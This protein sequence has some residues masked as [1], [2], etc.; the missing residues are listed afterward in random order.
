[1]EKFAKGVVKHRKII[2]IVYL[3]LM[4]PAVIGMVN[5][6]INYDMLSYLPKNLDSVKGQQIMLDNFGKG[7]FSYMLVEDKTPA[8]CA[9]LQTKIEALDH[10]D[11]VL[12]Y[13]TL[14][15]T[16]VPMSILPNSLYSRF[17]KDGSTLMEI[18]R[19]HV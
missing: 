7:A 5:T 15:N 4:I 2:I 14:L 16:D 11:S 18:G 12:W 10:V 13:N 19:A 6:R 3:V 1:M 17:N 9:E 8:E